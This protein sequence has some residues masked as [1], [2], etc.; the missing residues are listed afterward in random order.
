MATRKK[1]A[2]I[3]AAPMAISVE[4]AN[5]GDEITMTVKIKNT[6]DVALEG[7][8]LTFE[9]GEVQAGEG[10]SEAS[11]KVATITKIDPSDTATVTAKYIL[12]DG[13]KD[14]CTLKATYSCGEVNEVAQSN[15]ITVSEAV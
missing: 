7:G 13:D 5:V 15:P 10:Y 12:V 1:A 2:T 14:S 6:G 3:A 9:K 4:S 11:G 8:T